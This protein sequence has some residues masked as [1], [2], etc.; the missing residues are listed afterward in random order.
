MCSYPYLSPLCLRLGQTLGHINL[1]EDKNMKKIWSAPE[2][3][4]EQFTANEYVAACGDENKVSDA[5]A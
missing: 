5:E 2:A 4:A 1:R 3:I